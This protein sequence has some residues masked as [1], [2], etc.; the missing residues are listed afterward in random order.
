MVDAI[1]LVALSASTGGDYPALVRRTPGLVAYWRFEKTSGSIVSD[2]AGRH[3]GRIELAQR[4][5]AGRCGRGVRL[6]GK[7]SLVYLFRHP[8]LEARTGDFSV[9][10]WCRPEEL[11]GTAI[12][13]HKM[14]PFAR[15]N[16]GWYLSLHKDGKL[17]IRLTEKPGRQIVVQTSAPVVRFGQWNHVVAVRQGNTVR[18]YANGKRVA[19]SAGPLGLDVRRYGDI[20]VGGSPWGNRFKGLIDEVAYYH[21]ALSDDTIAVHSRA[22]RGS[23]QAEGDTRRPSR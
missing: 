8:D 17:H 14:S 11:T 19:E 22:S 20:I 7:R 13:A 21:V 4:V 16:A 23:P 12:L 10:L 18:L 2:V 5:S 15:G 3:H 9:E 1:L 6:D